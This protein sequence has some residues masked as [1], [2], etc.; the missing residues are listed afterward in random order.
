MRFRFLGG[1]EEVGKIG[2]YI[3]EG[4]ASA[5][6]EYGLKL[7]P[8]EAPTPPLPPPHH[9]DHVLLTHSHLDHCGMI[10]WLCRENPETRILS[11]NTS[12]EVAQLLWQDT[13]KIADME[14]YRRPFEPEDIRLAMSRF[15]LEDFGQSLDWGGFEVKLH[16]AG[17]IPGAAMF[18]INGVR[19]SLFT[20]DLHTI[21]TRLVKGANPVKCDNLFIEATYA[22]RNHLNSRL[23]E[24]HRFIEK[25]KEVVDNGGKA[26]IPCFAVG[27]TQ[28]VMLLL[29]DLKLNMWVDGM[30]KHVNRIYLDAA[31]HLNVK[32]FKKA[33]NRFR[34]VRVSSDRRKVKKDADVIVTTGGM[35]DGGPVLEYIEAFQNDTKT[36]VLMTGYQVPESNGRLLKETGE[37][38]VLTEESRNRSPEEILGPVETRRIKVKCQVE[39][40]DLSAHADHEQLLRFIR[41]CEPENVILMHSDQPQ[42][43]AKELE[44]EFNVIL[45]KTDQV[46]EI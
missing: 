23:K 20:G 42:L 22:G 40:F 37:I 8:K 46:I 29:K 38:E 24:E 10:P 13:I 41:G 11:T 16:R 26:I 32:D 18:E 3:E 12:Q 45:P 21:S 27:R 19:T 14:G 9:I 17:H 2:A 6:I 30:G 33:F 34:A 44:K 25:V 7:R 36:A 5:L 28:E 39:Q 4:G 43:L 1:A 31:A 35:L 15:I